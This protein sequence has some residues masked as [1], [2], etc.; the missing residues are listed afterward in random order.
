MAD[1][2]KCPQCGNPWHIGSGS[3]GCAGTPTPAPAGGERLWTTS[4]DAALSRIQ[5]LERELAEARVTLRQGIGGLRCALSII[6]DVVGPRVSVVRSALT[7]C[8][9]VYDHEGTVVSPAP[10]GSAVG[11]EEGEALAA[12]MEAW[13][14]STFTLDLQPLSFDHIKQAAALLRTL[15]ARA[16]TARREALEEAAAF[17]LSEENEPNWGQDNNRRT[18]HTTVKECAA[19]IRSLTAPAVEKE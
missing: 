9:R 5:S 8:E 18:A 6:G 15:S 3:G 11:E 13:C 19:L 16:E 12:V 17:I 4:L 14:D 2:A 1:D 7:E 10:P